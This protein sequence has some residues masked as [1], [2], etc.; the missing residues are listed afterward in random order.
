MVIFNLE[1]EGSWKNGISKAG[2]TAGQYKLNTVV[3]EVGNMLNCG[4]VEY[5]GWGSNAGEV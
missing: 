3:R 1:W 4:S 5:I 2:V